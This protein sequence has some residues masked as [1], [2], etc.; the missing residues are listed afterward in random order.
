MGFERR[1][2]TRRC[3]GV[4]RHE[5][6]RARGQPAPCRSWAR[7]VDHIAAQ[8]E[9]AR[10]IVYFSRA[11]GSAHVMNVLHDRNGVVFLDGQSGTFG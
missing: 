11:D 4:H 6:H 9:G 1:R 5:R 7:L 10:G 2:S 3:A 8:G